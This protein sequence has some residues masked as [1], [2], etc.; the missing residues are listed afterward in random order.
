MRTAAKKNHDPDQGPDAQAETWQTHAQLGKQQEHDTA[1]QPETQQQPQANLNILEESR[2]GL[3]SSRSSSNS[4]ARSTP[5][6]P[7]VAPSHKVHAIR[8]VDMRGLWTDTRGNRISAHLDHCGLLVATF[9]KPS[10]PTITLKLLPENDGLGWRCGNA[11]LGA[12]MRRADSFLCT[13]IFWIFPDDEV[14]T[15][16]LDGGATKKT[17][18][19]ETDDF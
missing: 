2:I 9:M 14:S 13:D 7:D 8:E 3:R 15:W 18:K 6:S 16:V 5:E 1:V 11:K 19:Q 12:S 17:T 10:R 4:T